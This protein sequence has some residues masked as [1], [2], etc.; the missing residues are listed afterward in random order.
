MPSQI[1]EL[2]DVEQ[3]VTRPVVMAIMDQVFEITSLSKDT[4]VYYNRMNGPHQTPGSNIDSVGE[5]DTRFMQD[6]ATYI[7]VTE[8]DDV[9]SLQEMITLDYDQI[10]VFEDRRLKCS[11]RPI[12][13]TIDVSIA[14]RYRSTSETEVLRWMAAMKTKASRGRDLNLHS[15]EYTYSVPHEFLELL[16]EIHRLREEVEPYNESFE[17]YLSNHATDRLTILSNRAGEKGILAVKE[18]QSR[19]QGLFD[20]A[21]L[22]SR[23]TH[24]QATGMWE[25]SFAY[26]FSFQKPE[27]MFIDYPTMVH[28]QLLPEHYLTP[29][30]DQEDPLY[31]LPYNNRTYRAL[32]AFESDTQ[33]VKV[34]SEEPFI[35]IPQFDDFKAEELI[36]GTASV[37]IALCSVEDDRR[38]LLN[39]NDLGDVI[40]DKD[41]LD[42]LQKELPYMVRVMK[43]VFQVSLYRNGKLAPDGILEVGEDLSIRSVEPLNLRQ[44]HHVRFSIYA[45]L[46]LVSKEAIDRLISSPKAFIKMLAAI[47]E[48]LRKNPD[49]QDL[50][51]RTE[52]EAYEL[53]ELYHYLTGS[54]YG[55]QYSHSTTGSPQSGSGVPLGWHGATAWTGS[56]G[57]SFLDCVDI[58]MIRNYF[59]KTNPAFYRMTTN[60]RPDSER[61]DEIFIEQYYREKRRRR[62]DK[63]YSGIP[64]VST[65]DRER[66]A[67]F[68]SE[69]RRQFVSVMTTGIIARSKRDLKDV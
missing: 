66:M 22:P 33:A 50:G 10:P 2:V 69:K 14:I 37:F 25:I 31:R 64:Y 42:H 62:P 56:E 46:G 44:F 63:N 47:N 36:P 20:F 61:T 32:S 8:T 48:N 29:V 12:Y 19:I 18:K 57:R 17:G 30:L 1:V 65:I 59:K 5:K 21:G 13:S 7:E 26:K 27:S 24:E 53:S 43:S 11:L 45:D 3:T 40:V 38:T 58:V 52:I 28:N 6:R 60:N 9:N 67:R 34:R 41:I 51:K 23:P 39:L 55:N 49:F 16:T 4:T 15:V 35:R 54:Y 68:L